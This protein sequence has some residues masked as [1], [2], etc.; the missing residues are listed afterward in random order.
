MTIRYFHNGPK[1]PYS[2]IN[3]DT[4]EL[5]N[6]WEKAGHTPLLFPGN[7]TLLKEA[8]EKAQ[9]AWPQI[10]KWIDQLVKE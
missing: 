9:Q 10:N 2:H 3:E 5:F 7:K 4:L 8:N 1:L 6:G